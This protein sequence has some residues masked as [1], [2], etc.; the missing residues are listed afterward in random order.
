MKR[1][2]L[3]VAVIGTALTYWAITERFDNR[4]FRF[5]CLVLPSLIVG[6]KLGEEV[7]HMYREEKLPQWAYYYICKFNL[8][9]TINIKPIDD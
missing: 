4:A 3:I 5:I 9:K 1:L 7:E 6:V 8:M 2:F